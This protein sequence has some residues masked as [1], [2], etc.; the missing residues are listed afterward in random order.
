MLVTNACHHL[1]SN[2]LVPSASWLHRLAPIQA[3]DDKLYN[4]SHW[5]MYHHCI[6]NIQGRQA[7]P[8]SVRK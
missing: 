2:Q 6:L 3:F 7:T 5:G 8:G 1:L 4:Q